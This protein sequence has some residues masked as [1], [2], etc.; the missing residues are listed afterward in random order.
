MNR[1]AVRL[2][3]SKIDGHSHLMKFSVYAL[4]DYFWGGD[5]KQYGPAE[6]LQAWEVAQVRSRWKV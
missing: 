5:K 1:Y 3:L 4:I 2:Y 6:Y